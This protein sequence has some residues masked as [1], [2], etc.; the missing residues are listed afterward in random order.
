MYAKP[1]EIPG[2]VEIKAAKVSAPPALD[3]AALVDELGPEVVGL[4]LVN[5]PSYAFPWHGDKIPVPLK[6][7]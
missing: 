5:T 4:Q 2:M 3:A 7:P 6:T 1:V